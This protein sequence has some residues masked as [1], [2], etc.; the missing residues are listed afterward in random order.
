[1]ALTGMQD[2]GCSAFASGSIFAAECFTFMCTSASGR[3]RPHT[4]APQPLADLLNPTT[5]LPCLLQSCISSMLAGEYSVFKVPSGLD[6]EWDDAMQAA[7]HPSSFYYVQIAMLHF[8][9]RATC[10]DKSTSAVTIVRHSNMWS[11]KGA[12]ASGQSTASASVNISDG[13]VITVSYAVRASSSS[14]N[15]WLHVA[16]SC[17]VTVG[18]IDLP[19]G[20]DAAVRSMQVAELCDVFCSG[21]DAYA[22]EAPA[23]GT[24]EGIDA[25]AA[26]VFRCAAFGFELELASYS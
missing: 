1:M 5:R 10:S 16:D 22:A 18:G 19:M 11:L 13:T 24:P 20:L 25:G 3:S 26:V 2:D 14:G 4:A 7:G 8:Q 15:H 23:T 12:G 21:E 17:D 6:R 9:R